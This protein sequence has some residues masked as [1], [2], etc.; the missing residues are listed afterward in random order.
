MKILRTENNLLV[1]KKDFIEMKNEI[2]LYSA[3][4]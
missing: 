1:S 4:N 2:Y 3:K